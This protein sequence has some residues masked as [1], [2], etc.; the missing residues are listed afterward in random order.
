MTGV[1]TCALPI[2]RFQLRGELYNVFNKVNFDNPNTGFGTANFGRVTS[3]RDM[4]RIEIGGKIL[5]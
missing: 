2:S 3:A 4:R 1:Q 5:F